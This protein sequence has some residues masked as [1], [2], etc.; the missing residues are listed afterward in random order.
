MLLLYPVV[1]L[2]SHGLQKMSVTSL[3]RTSMISS[4]TNFSS[5]LCPSHP[6]PRVHRIPVSFSLPFASPSGTCVTNSHSSPFFPPHLASRASL[7]S[8]ASPCDFPPVFR[9]I[10]RFRQLLA[11]PSRYLLTISKTRGHQTSYRC[12]RY[13]YSALVFPTISRRAEC[14]AIVVASQALPLVASLISVFP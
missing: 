10:S 11:Y 12:L 3:F 7:A 9:F 1:T 5:S 6:F 14:S 2:R 13:L 8:L 4:L